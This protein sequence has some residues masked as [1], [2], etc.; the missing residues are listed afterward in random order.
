MRSVTIVRYFFTQQIGDEV[1]VLRADGPEGWFDGP[2]EDRKLKFPLK[3]NDDWR[4]QWMLEH[5]WRQFFL[6]QRGE[7]VEYQGF[8][9]IDPMKIKLGKGM[10]A[11]VVGIDKGEV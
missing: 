8:D 7:W 4:S 5:D 3:D 11:N 9:L 6:D 1:I 2:R 10:K